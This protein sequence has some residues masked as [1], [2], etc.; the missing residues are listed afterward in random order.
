MVSIMVVSALTPKQGC[1]S[2]SMAWGAK[3]L[4]CHTS[5][6][7]PLPQDGWN[8]PNAQRILRWH[9]ASLP[10]TSPQ[11]H[12]SKATL[13]TLAHPSTQNK[14]E[15]H[16]PLR[17]CC[18]RYTLFTEVGLHLVMQMHT[19]VPALVCTRVLVMHITRVPALACARNPKP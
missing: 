2:W 15:N 3:V 8:H 5:S 9:N 11:H 18:V 14:H 7:T 1:T 13:N 16:C 10:R 12:D 19:L 4:C 17:C 6:S